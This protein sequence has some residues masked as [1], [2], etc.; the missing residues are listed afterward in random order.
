VIKAENADEQDNKDENRWESHGG[1]ENQMP[2][3]MKMKKRE[4]FAEMI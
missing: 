1:D 2:N 3:M 4:N